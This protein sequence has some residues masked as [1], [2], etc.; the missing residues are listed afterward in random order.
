MQKLMKLTSVIT[1]LIIISLVLC[2]CSGKNAS[3]SDGGFYIKVGDTEL[4]KEYIGYFFYIAQKNM[5][6]EA[7][8]TL[9]EGGNS[10]A[11]DVAA[12]WETTEIEGRSAVDVARDLAADNAVIQ[13]VQ[14][15]RAVKEGIKLSADEERAIND[16]IS[17][18]IE[19]VG[20][21]DKFNAQLSDMGC[22]ANAYKKIL[23]ENKYVQKLYDKYDSD[24][25]LSLSNDELSAYTEKYS[26][27]IPAEQIFEYA[28]K[29]KFNKLALSW[30]KDFEIEISDK[31]MKEFKVK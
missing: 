18:A 17:A 13:T 2:S 12:F 29:D 7:G 22:D 11:E 3:K 26:D 10:T 15:L 1:A 30:E 14:Y 9:G 24:G 25:K 8:M 4:G 28:K 6:Q 19:S 5:T 31:K 23:T 20:G 16:N 27:E 21:K